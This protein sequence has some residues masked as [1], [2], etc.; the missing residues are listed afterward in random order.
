M[1]VD[2]NVAPA[3]PA[4]F[5]PSLP[6]DTGPI[7]VRAATQLI[8]DQ[9]EKAIK[10]AQEPQKQPAQRA[11][12]GKFAAALQES[13][14]QAG[15]AGPDDPVPSEA[16]QDDPADLPPIDPPRS[17]SK[18]DKELFNA[19]PRETQ[20]RVS[21]RERSRESDFLRRQNEATEKT[22]AL[23]AK[24]QAAEQAR[25]QYETAAQNALAV[26][27]QQ[28]SSEFA[29][30]KTHADVQKLAADD[31]F[32][33]A[34]WQARQMQFNAQAQEVENL[35]RQRDEHKRKTFETWAD[36]Q[37]GK[38]KK[39]FPEFADEEKAAEIRGKLARY[40]TDEIGVPK[41]ALSQL[42]N[43]ELFRDA[44]YQRVLYDA[45]RF[46]TA[47]QKAKAATAVPKPPVQRPGTAPAKGAQ[48]ADQIVAAQARL[49]NAKGIEASKAAADLIRL[50]R[51]ARR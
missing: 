7:N 36:E 23:E 8:A 24:E 14:A 46:H 42:R 21:E 45:Y 50:Q 12:D 32:R 40:L 38:F 51:A 1:E 43:E 31:P 35:N 5:T 15:D 17:W 39:Q 33:F 28:M 13:P 34:Q 30:I 27:Q 18:E 6:P 25:Q 4:D 41:E 16:V 29:D 11:P 47:Q 2:T 3:A 49:K 48:V 26:L 22:K 37:D 20:E 10:S 44:M 19:L 9:R